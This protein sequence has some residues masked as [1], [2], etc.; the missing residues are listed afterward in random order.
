MVVYIYN[1]IFKKKYWKN[2]LSNCLYRLGTIEN[3]DYNFLIFQD[4]YT[5]MFVYVYILRG[6]EHLHI[7]NKKYA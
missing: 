7:F 2:I 1:M 6:C 3:H 5:S 4:V